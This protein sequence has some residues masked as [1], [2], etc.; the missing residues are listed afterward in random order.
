MINFF[1]SYFY[2]F[3]WIHVKTPYDGHYN[4]L[5][6]ELDG[7]LPLNSAKESVTNPSF[8]LAKNFDYS[9]KNYLF[10]VVENVGQ[11]VL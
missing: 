11:F 10:T 7:E 5:S 6:P 2:P 8:N 3:R 4:F 9:G 1:F